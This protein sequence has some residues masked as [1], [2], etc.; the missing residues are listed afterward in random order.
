MK[1][2]RRPSGLPWKRED[3]FPLPIP[4]TSNRARP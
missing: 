3:D 2:P 4:D 1:H